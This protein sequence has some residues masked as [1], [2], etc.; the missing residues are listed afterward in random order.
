LE[1]F[2][3]LRQ[4]FAQDLIETQFAKNPTGSEF[5]PE[6]I[7]SLMTYR[8]EITTGVYKITPADSFSRGENGLYL[9]RGEGMSPYIYDFPV[10]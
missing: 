7:L 6:K 9:S 2:R 10:G 1:S 4:P 8:S 5:L 3:P